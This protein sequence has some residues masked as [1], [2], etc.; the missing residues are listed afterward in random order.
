MLLQSAQT[1]LLN[2]QSD[3]I[4][5]SGNNAVLRLSENAKRML[6]AADQ[7]LVNNK[8][9]LAFQLIQAATRM[10]ARIQREL[11]ESSSQPDFSALERKYLQVINA[12]TNLEENK[13]FA[14][15][16]QSVLR[17]LKRFAEE[18][19]RFLDNGNYVL[20]D[21]YFN[22]ALEQI[23]QY[24]SGHLKVYRLWAVESVPPMIV[25]LRI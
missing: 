5:K 15:K 4:Q 2:L 19:K 22:T 20:A 7:A 3:R 25:N 17:Q 1:P 8:P 13:T 18:G 10:S 9:N 11:R 21:E 16:F 12:I 14:D 6:S 23:N 24:V